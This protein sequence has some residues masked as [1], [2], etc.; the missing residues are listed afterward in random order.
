MLPVTCLMRNPSCFDKLPAGS[1]EKSLH[2]PQVY[3]P[4]VS[5]FFL[6]FYFFERIL[7]G[8]FLP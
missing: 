4:S 1:L 8:D 3:V 7:T 6:F 2:S 5:D